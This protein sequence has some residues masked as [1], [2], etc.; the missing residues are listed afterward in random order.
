MQYIFHGSFFISFCDISFFN[1]TLDFNTKTLS[2]FI[3]S[4][5]KIEYEVSINKV[6]AEK[7]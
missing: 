5:I 3:F 6:A 7:L 1:T 2:I 4:D